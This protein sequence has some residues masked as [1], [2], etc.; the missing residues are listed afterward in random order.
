[1][2]AFS[3]H[4][5]GSETREQSDRAGADIAVPTVQVLI[6]AW[7]SHGQAA[8]PFSGPE[9]QRLDGS[10]FRSDFAQ[11]WA[12]DVSK[13]PSSS[14]LS[15]TIRF[16]PWA[17]PHLDGGFSSTLDGPCPFSMYPNPCFRLSLGGTR[18][19]AISLPISS[20]W[21]FLVL[22]FSRTWQTP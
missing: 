7:C 10:S 21:I 20:P 22:S 2:C 13:C 16:R 12:G 9:K 1:M 3:L 8:T 17:G 15:G 18:T 5:P 14:S 4:S 11:C 6:R 19:E